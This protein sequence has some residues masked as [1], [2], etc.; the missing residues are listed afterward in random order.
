[1]AEVTKCDEEVVEFTET[2][3]SALL[4]QLFA[5]YPSL[6]EKDFQVA[7]NNTIVSGDAEIMES[8]IALLP[9]FS[10]G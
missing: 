3:L 4:E 8:E 5:K 2:T 6:K 7:Q 9:P 10:G 1:M